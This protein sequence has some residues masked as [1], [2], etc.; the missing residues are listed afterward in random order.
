MIEAEIPDFYEVLQISPRADHETIERMFRH[1]AKRLHPDNADTGN[2]ERFTMALDAYRV[3]SDPE[4]R[5][6]YDA[7]YDRV[8]Q[9]RWRVFDQD[10]STND[11]SAD[12]QIRTAILGL[13][14]TARRA[15]PYRPGLGM[16]SLE[17]ILSCPEE[18]MAFHI[19]Y[20]RENGLV[21]RLENGSL[22][23]TARGV[24]RVIEAGGPVRQ[25]VHL[26]RA[27]DGNA[28]LDPLTKIA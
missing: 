26:L 9:N 3:L 27:G 12:R 17:E 11:V 18:L 21:D 4:R 15:D 10:S 1:L 22:A 7:H 14:Y 25:G 5:A 20:L 28:V 16:I 2:S 23:I 13:L 8:R 24:D 19:W 6:S